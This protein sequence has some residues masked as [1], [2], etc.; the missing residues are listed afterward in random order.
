MTKGLKKSI[1]NFS[2]WSQKNW[3]ALVI[4]AIT[5]MLIFVSL[6][7]VSWLFGYWSNALYGTKFELNSC[8][9]GISAVV[10]G[11]GGV[12][13][14][15]KAAWTKYKTDSEFNSKI[16]EKPDHDDT[17]RNNQNIIGGKGD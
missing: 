6:I 17:I 8:W 9:Q 5:N 15:A 7:A 1:V 2:K 12:T 3:L 13:A 11:M 16:G 14:L 4:F 10:A